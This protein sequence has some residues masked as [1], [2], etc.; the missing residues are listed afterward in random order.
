VFFFL[1]SGGTS[2][3]GSAQGHARIRFSSAVVTFGSQRCAVCA[4]ACA[5]S[6]ARRRRQW[7]RRRILGSI[8]LLGRDHTTLHALLSWDPASRLRKPHLG[9]PSAQNLR[10]EHR[11]Y[12]WIQPPCAPQ[13]ATRPVLSHGLED[14]QKWS[15][16]TQ[17]ASNTHKK[18][19]KSIQRPENCHKQPILRTRSQGL[20]FTHRSCRPG[21]YFTAPP[22]RSSVCSRCLAR[23]GRPTSAGSFQSAS[24][25][26]NP[27][28]LITLDGPTAATNGSG[29]P[30]QATPV[31]TAARLCRPPCESPD[32][33]PRP[34]PPP[35]WGFGRRLREQRAL[36]PT[37]RCLAS[38]AACAL[39]LRRRL[40]LTSPRSPV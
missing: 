14:P 20:H 6:A 28:P 15:F 8:A 25:L 35:A 17:K 26:A 11:Q 5:R 27:H 19:A 37:P 40:Q 39:P 4:L 3:G 22:M 38:C 31:L 24:L 10:Y 36:G 1:R 33:P 13:S 16:E 32:P 30:L 21:W 2:E 34:L 12:G 7:D 18:P 23:Q 29:A 9:G